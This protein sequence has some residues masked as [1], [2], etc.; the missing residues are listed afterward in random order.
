MDR[1]EFMRM[2][3]SNLN[4]NFIKFYGLDINYTTIWYNLHPYSKL[5]SASLM[6]PVCT[7]TDR[8]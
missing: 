1:P 5:H 6:P 4:P 7:K 2:E 3:L 8:E